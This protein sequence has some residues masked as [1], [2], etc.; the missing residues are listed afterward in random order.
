LSIL[1][2]SPERFDEYE[3]QVREEYSWVPDV[4]FKRKRRSLL[5]EFLERPTIF[6]TAGF[7]DRYDAQARANLKRS[8]KR[9]GG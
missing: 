3:R 1:G 6:N 8:I 9:L 4:L 7:I 5:T 2:T